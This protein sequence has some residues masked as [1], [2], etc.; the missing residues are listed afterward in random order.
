MTLTPGQFQIGDFVFGRNTLFTVEGFEIG[1]YDIN[2]QDFQASISDEMRF[3]RDSLKPLPIQLSINALENYAMTNIIAATGSED[4]DIDNLNPGDF[5]NEWRADAVR[6]EWG[7]LKPLYVCR[8]DGTS[9]MVFGRPGKL[10]ISK[11]S[12]KN[13]FRKIVAEYRRSDTYAYSTTEWIYTATG[14]P[15][16]I[17]RPAGD[18][19]AWLRLWLTGPMSNPV[20]QLGWVTVQLSVTIQAGEVVEVSS[21]PWSRRVVRL[22]DGA[23]FAAGLTSP[24]LD[25]LKFE[26]E[27][28]TELSWTASETTGASKCQLLWRDA[29]QVIL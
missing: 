25:K 19:P 18:A 9:V 23:S 1:G 28:E 6:S 11:P 14:T 13:A 22:N 2:V 10:A 8:E 12:G 5:V 7:A 26:A 4:P 16:V 17:E 24:Y 20:I 27:A 21:Y 15:Q 29:W 3:G